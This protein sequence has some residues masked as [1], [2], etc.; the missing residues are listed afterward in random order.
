MPSAIMG[1]RAGR[2]LEV[3]ALVALLGVGAAL[4]VLGAVVP[5][6]VA[7]PV[8]VNLTIAALG[9]TLAG[10]LWRTGARTPPW[11]LHLGIGITLVATTVMV[12]AAA[13]GEGA[14]SAGV[15]FL[16]LA[17]YA[18]IA[19]TPRARR[20]VVVLGGAGLAIGLT[21]G[22][23]TM[24]ALLAWLVV[25]ISAAV[26]SEILGG[27][28]V[29]LLALAASD[30]L[31]GLPNRHGLRQLATRDLADAA[32]T[33]APIAVA[34]IDLDGFKG[35]NDRDGHAAGDALLSSLAGMWRGQLRPRDT[36]ART[37]GD[38]FVFVLPATTI[39]D[40]RT[41]LERLGRTSPA[42]WSV[43]IVEMSA[44]EDLD[45]GLRRADQ[46]MYRDKSTRRADHGHGLAGDVHQDASS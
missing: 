2:P 27:Q 6:P 12:A 10:V 22:I 21:I 19:L 42:R 24:N 23:G 15:T 16:W 7:P 34:V 30:P 26:A 39:A 43:G 28:H 11:L 37:G 20:A 32:R 40:A 17:I 46:A 29:R 38:E 31:T 3:W 44:G 41:L 8:A 13:T 36:V 9:A 33:G 35:V 45:A 1:V 25:T 14:V 18:A 5:S 4:C